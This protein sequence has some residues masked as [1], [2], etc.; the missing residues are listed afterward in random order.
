ME[1]Q[2]QPNALAAA[3]PNPPLFWQSFTPENLE[4]ISFL[5][6]QQESKSKDYDA[7]KELPIRLLELPPELRW[8]QPPEPPSDGKFRC[9]GDLF[10]VCL[11]S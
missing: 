5:R 3:F 7:A 8:L 4:R 6:S 1:E 10:D 2:P 11:P 9:F